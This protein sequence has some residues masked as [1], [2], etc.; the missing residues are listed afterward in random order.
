MRSLKRLKRADDGE[1]ERKREKERETEKRKKEEREAKEKK[2]KKEESE[3]EE[4]KTCGICR[5]EIVRERDLVFPDCCFKPFCDLCLHEWFKISTTCPL[6]RGQVSKL[7]NKKLVVI[8]RILAVNKT[9]QLI[10]DLQP[11]DGE[12][13]PYESEDDSD[14]EEDERERR[15]LD[16]I[17]YER[18]LNED[19]ERDGF[20]VSDDEATDSSSS[21]A[22]SSGDEEESVASSSSDSDCRVTAAFVTKRKRSSVA[23]HI[24]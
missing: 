23:I 3:K 12:E 17:V 20:V 15:D 19:Y 22:S 14:D 9:E 24:D 8:E 2:E 10:P 21:L 13:E 18:R 1:A 16:E 5:E 6:C 7:V 4:K 11:S